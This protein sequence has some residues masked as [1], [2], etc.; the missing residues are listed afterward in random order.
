[1]KMRTVSTEMIKAHLEAALWSSF[2]WEDLDENDEP[3][4]LD[5]NFTVEDFC[6]DHCRM[7]ARDLQIFLNLCESW[8]VDWSDEQIGHDFWLSRNGH[9]AGF[10]DSNSPF[11][12]D[13][14]A[15]AVKFPEIDLFV[16]D[17]T[18]RGSSKIIVF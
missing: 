18:G 11:A 3:T 10:F 17:G 2:D 15:I 7:L 1:M 16:T 13:L 4:P 8:L 6:S 5:K 12:E 14:Q 9:G